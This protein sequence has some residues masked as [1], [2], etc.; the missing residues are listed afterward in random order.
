MLELDWGALVVGAAGVLTGVG[1][2]IRAR[3]NIAEK[4]A[5]KNRCE[6]LWKQDTIN[7][8]RQEQAEL[9]ANR[10]KAL[11]AQIGQLS[12]RVTAQRARID[13]F[14]AEVIELRADRQRKDDQIARLTD[15]VHTLELE[16]ERLKGQRDARDEQVEL[17]KQ[18]LALLRGQ[19][20]ALF[21]L[22][23]EVSTL[24]QVVTRPS[25]TPSPPTPLPDGEGEKPE[26]VESVVK[27]G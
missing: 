6:E 23:R 26:A 2:W 18:E 5:E 3:A 16:N 22:V 27:S 15:R 24:V 12:E 21:Q 7:E 11:S 13:S 25:P 17:L 9:M 8:L 4:D 19:S 1:F 14:E 20:S 10:E